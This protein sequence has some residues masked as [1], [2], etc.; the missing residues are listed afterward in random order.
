MATK[1]KETV[2]GKEKRGISPSYPRQTD[3]TQRRR[4]PNSST[5]TSPDHKH[6]AA[7]EKQ[8]PNYLKPT[9]SSTLDPSNSKQLPRKQGSNDTT[10]PNLNR[11]RSFDKPP[12]PI[13]LQKPQPSLSP[14]ALP[15]RSSSFSA[16][17]TNLPKPHPERLSKTPKE[18]GKHHSI[19]AKPASAKK[20]SSITKKEINPSIALTT[21]VPSIGSPDV[22]DSTDIANTAKKL[23]SQQ[24]DS[25]TEAGEQMLHD[26]SNTEMPAEILKLED[27]DHAGLVQSVVESQEGEEVEVC[28]VYS[29]S[30]DQNESL[31]VQMEE[32]EEKIHYEETGSH[33]HEVKD[34]NKDENDNNGKQEESYTGESQIEDEWRVGEEREKTLEEKQAVDEESQNLNSKEI[35][36]WENNV[37]EVKPE[38]NVVPKHQGGQG[39]KESPAYNDVIE[40]T[41]SKLREQKKNNV[42]ALAG[43]FETVISLQEP[44]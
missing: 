21:K 37:K 12:S 15:L 34:Q 36:E 18:V 11:R 13:R 8:I 26:E 32:P 4:S 28:E 2:Q 40:E 9:Q 14:R 29:I 27:K 35:E 20:T 5:R 3:T 7:S 1:G 10:R 41:A 31:S 17:T 25:V 38:E 23:E 22:L 44:K 42:K 24:E 6:A 16:R 39:K 33:H 43:A 19:Y 30:E